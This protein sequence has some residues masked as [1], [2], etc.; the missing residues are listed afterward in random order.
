MDPNLPNWQRQTAAAC[1]LAGEGCVT[2]SDANRLELIRMFVEVR[3]RPAARRDEEYR[4]TPL[5][6]AARRGRREVVELLLSLGSKVALPEDE[7]WAT[8]L[9]LE[10]RS[11]C[12]YMPTSSPCCSTAGRD[13]GGFSPDQELMKQAGTSAAGGPCRDPHPRAGSNMV[14]RALRDSSGTWLKLSMTC[15]RWRMRSGLAVPCIGADGPQY[16]S[17]TQKRAAPVR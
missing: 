14:S 5:A 6:W 11:A 12:V 2:I 17:S 3:G 16:G 9:G 15:C 8:P 4:S 1:A 13:H 7:P 10:P